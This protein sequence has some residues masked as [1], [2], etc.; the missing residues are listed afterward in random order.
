[1]NWIEE[2]LKDKKPYEKITSATYRFGIGIFNNWIC[3]GDVCSWK[4]IDG[5]IWHQYRNE[6]PT[7][8]F[9]K[10]LLQLKHDEAEARL[11]MVTTTY[12]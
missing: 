7:K 10:A 11:I 12:D 8:N 2:Q 1:M 3:G 9:C 6:E 5:S 4:D